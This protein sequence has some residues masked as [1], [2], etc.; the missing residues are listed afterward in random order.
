MV[1]LKR[2]TKI[3]K[4][5]RLYGTSKPSV[6]KD[7]VAIIFN[8]DSHVEKKDT[9]VLDGKHDIVLFKFFSFAIFMHQFH[10]R[11]LYLFLIEVEHQ[12]SRTL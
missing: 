11:I 10:H 6:R 7:A 2:W 8:T 5:A 9:T 4:T 1:Q 12:K 3:A